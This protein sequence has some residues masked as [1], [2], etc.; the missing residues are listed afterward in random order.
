MRCA[1]FDDVNPGLRNVAHVVSNLCQCIAGQR[2]RLQAKD[3]FRALDT[4]GDGA[5]SR[6][7]VQK[8]PEH[9]RLQA[10]LSQADACSQC[11][12]LFG[13]CLS[14]YGLDPMELRGQTRR[15]RASSFAYPELR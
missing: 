5:V 11:Y 6:Q 12:L 10:L 3:T 7:E 4:N 8:A 13:D 14:P 15:N 2:R 9:C 1:D